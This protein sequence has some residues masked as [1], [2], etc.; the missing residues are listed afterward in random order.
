MDN[1]SLEEIQIAAESLESTRRILS[2]A[3]ESQYVGIKIITILDKQGE[4]LNHIEDMGHINTD[5]GEAEKTLTERNKCRALC[6]CPRNRT[7]NFGW[8]RLQ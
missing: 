2:L 1:L 3:I 7:K 6:V 4:Q 8:S 5:M